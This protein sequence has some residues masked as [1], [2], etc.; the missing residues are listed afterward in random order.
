MVVLSRHVY[1]QH[2]L[3]THRPLPI[4]HEHR[5]EPASLS[6]STQERP[7]I[8]IV[9]GQ[10]RS[11]VPSQLVLPWSSLQLPQSYFASASSVVFSISLM[12]IGFPSITSLT[13]FLA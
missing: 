6:P 7:V 13:C 12:S 1:Q 9:L 5:S 10:L 8:R 3:R 4:L 2:L 11:S